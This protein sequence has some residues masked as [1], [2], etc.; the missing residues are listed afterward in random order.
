MKTISEATIA[1]EMTAEDLHD[2][3]WALAHAAHGSRGKGHK[4]LADRRDHLAGMF[5][6]QL[7]E[8]RQREAG[9]A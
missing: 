3:Y 1:V 9:N 6:R 2:C 5:S 8:L 4:A 7:A